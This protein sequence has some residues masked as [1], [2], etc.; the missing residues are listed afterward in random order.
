MRMV[1][2]DR[3]LGRW[4]GRVMPRLV[5]ER[6]ISVRAEKVSKDEGGGGPPGET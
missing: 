1:V 6:V 4:L 3:V 5:A 2:P